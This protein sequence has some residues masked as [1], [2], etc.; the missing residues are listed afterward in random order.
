MPSPTLSTDAATGAPEIP[1]GIEQ[2]PP[3]DILTEQPL[4]MP[5]L[6]SPKGVN[7]NR[8]RGDLISSISTG[9]SAN[10]Q[11]SWS[12][13]GNNSTTA[14][15][16]SHLMHPGLTIMSPRLLS[17]SY[18]IPG[19]ASEGGE[20]LTK[21]LP[22]SQQLTLTTRGSRAPT[23][24]DIRSISSHAQSEALVQL[25]QKSILDMEDV[26]GGDFLNGGRLPLSAKLAAA[27]LAA[28]GESIALE[29]RFKWV[30][31]GKNRRLPV[32]AFLDHLHLSDPSCP[33]ALAWCR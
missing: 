11:L 5:Y 29:R 4:T 26:A 32:R 1:F 2:P 14:P 30:E 9:G 16:I 10:P 12:S 13:I 6:S 24:M 33:P 28:Y 18:H 22:D 21:T 31:K 17:I 20:K 8:L 25:A 27:K 7:D 19:L 15:A 3:T 23:D